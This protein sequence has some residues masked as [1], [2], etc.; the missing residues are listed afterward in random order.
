VLDPICAAGSCGSDGGA[1]E[2]GGGSPLPPAITL[3]ASPYA[4]C[5]T[6]LDGTLRCWGQNTDG[7]L[8]A[9][10]TTNLATPAR[11]GADADWVEVSGAHGHCARKSDRSL[12]CW[13]PEY[14]VP[15]TAIVADPTRVEPSIAWAHSIAGGAHHCA[16]AS[17]QSLYCW[18][19]NDHGQLGLGDTAT[20]TAATPLASAWTSASVGLTHTCGLQGD[21]SLWCWGHN[22]Q[23]QLGLSDTTDRNVPTRVGTGSWSAV[24]AGGNHTCALDSGGALWCWGENAYGEV[25]TGDTQEQNAPVHVGTGT[26]RAVAS[27]GGLSCAIATD[28]TLWCWGDFGQAVQP[29][30]SRVPQQVD[31]STDWTGIAAGSSHACG[32]RAQQTVFCLGWNFDGQLAQPA[33]VTYS[34]TAIAVGF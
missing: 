17:D 3:A 29:G 34:A 32:V 5:A 25:G 19:A 28:G 7:A 21:G 31:A 26:Y 27:G 15:S 30:Q 8:V 2:G 33:S 24:S 4:T 20:R 9:G 12:Y 22:G 16:L 1:T 11:I 10:G 23:G 14:A 6:L 13:G 18:G